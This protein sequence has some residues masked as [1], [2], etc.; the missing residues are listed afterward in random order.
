MLGPGCR[1]GPPDLSVVLSRI[2]TLNCKCELSVPFHPATT[3]SPG[4]KLW[5]A[6][7]AA[8]CCKLCRRT[9][10]ARERSQSGQRLL[11][12]GAG[13]NW[14]C[15]CCAQCYQQECEHHGRRRAHDAAGRCPAAQRKQYKTAEVGSSS[16]TCDVKEHFVYVCK[17]AL[18]VWFVH[19]KRAVW[20]LLWQGCSANRAANCRSG[21]Y[22]W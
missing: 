7:V 1:T 9:E 21:S 12:L 2:Q 19:I 5:P 18:N 17:K 14:A 11:A 22:H 20:L 3:T 8:D 4:S 15:A 6:C 13:E 16:V 10:A